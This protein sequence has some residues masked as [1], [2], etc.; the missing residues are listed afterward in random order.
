MLD[1][2]PFRTSLVR[3]RGKSRLYLN[4][5]MRRD[6]DVDVGDVVSISL[7]FDPK[8]RVQPIPLLLRTA[9]RA[10]AAARRQWEALRPSHRKEILAYLNSLKTRIGVERNVAKVLA[11]LRDP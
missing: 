1:R 10:D 7:A 8:P 5:Q 6:A 9:L 3:F 2:K 11:Q 4:T